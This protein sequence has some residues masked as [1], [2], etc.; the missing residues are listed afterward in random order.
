MTYL[1]ASH[2]AWISGVLEA[3][4]VALKK[5]LEEESESRGGPKL[6]G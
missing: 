1:K 2:V 5:E 3:V 4:L 6:N